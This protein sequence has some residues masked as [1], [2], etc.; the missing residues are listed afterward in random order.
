MEQEM[1]RISRPLVEQLIDQLDR[2]ATFCEKARSF[3]QDDMY[4]TQ[5]DATE[6]YAGSSGYARA[7]MRDILQTL[8]S[9]LN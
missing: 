7:T 6:F 3:T 4:D 8:E 9:H 1:I 2:S 5:A